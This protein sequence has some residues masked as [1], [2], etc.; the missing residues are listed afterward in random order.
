MKNSTL[1]IGG[2]MRKHLVLSLIP[3][4]DGFCKKKKIKTI[5]FEKK[6]NNKTISDNIYKNLKS[7]YRVKYLDQINISKFKAIK[8]IFHFISFLIIFLLSFFFKKSYLLKKN[9]KWEFKQAL[10][11]Y[12]DTSI[13]NNKFKLDEV[14]LKSRIIT[15]L[16]ISRKL[17]DYISLRINGINYAFL[18]HFVYSERFL[19]T[20]LRS[21][22][23]KTYRYNGCILIQQERNFDR[24]SKFIDKKLYNKSFKIFSK[25]KI[26]NYWQDLKRGYSK[27]EEVNFAAKIKSK[28]KKHKLL[29]ANVIMLHIFKDSSFDNIDVKRIFPDYYTWVLETLKIIR[30]SNETWILRKHPS[31]DRWGENQKKIINDMLKKVFGEKKPKNILFEENFRSNMEQFKLSKRI[32]TYS[33]SSHLEAACVGSKP[34]VISDVVLTQY[35]KNLVFKPKTYEEY[36]ELLLTR[37]KKHF[38]LKKKETN[39]PKRILFLLHNFLDLSEDTGCSF[40][41]RGDPKHKFASVLKKVKKK[42]KLNNKYLYDLGYNLSNFYKQAINKKYFNKMLNEKN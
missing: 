21:K 35:S 14:E 20:M 13:I 8:Y 15:C 30:D 22:N 27:N 11:C 5:I 34:I 3:L 37:N 16:Q 36:R 10:H 32:I 1:Y 38:S 42:I 24:D 12:W 19:F 18:G 25:R 41:F 29:N 23:V 26:D 7:K 2:G 6:I 39:M 31:S 28:N 9:V 4:I 40:V 33:G 17:L